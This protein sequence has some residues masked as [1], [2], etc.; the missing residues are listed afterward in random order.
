MALKSLFFFF[1]VASLHILLWALVFFGG[2]M[3]YAETRSFP[4]G[5]LVTCCLWLMSHIARE[6]VKS[7]SSDT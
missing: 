1:V 3:A 7:P 4:L 2:V 6:M 5:I